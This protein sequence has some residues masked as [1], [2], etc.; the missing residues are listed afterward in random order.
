[1]DLLDHDFGFS[2]LFFPFLSHLTEN[3]LLCLACCLG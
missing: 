2:E 3:P 1:M